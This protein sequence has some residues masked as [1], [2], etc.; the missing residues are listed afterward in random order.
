MK[1]SVTIL[2]LLAKTPF[3]DKLARAQLQHVI[4]HSKEWEAAPGT[5]ISNSSKGPDN[6]WVLLDGGWQIEHGGRAYAAGHA[7]AAKW[8]GGEVFHALRATSRLVAT[9]TSYVMRITIADLDEMLKEGFAFD[10][11]LREGLRYYE[12]LFG[13]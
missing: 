8:Y 4:A 10:R 6:F 2:D 12:A 1:P 11:H 3:F 9:E 5:E 7:D 13:S